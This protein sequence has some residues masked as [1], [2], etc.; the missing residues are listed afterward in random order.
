MGNQCSNSKR[1]KGLFRDAKYHKV[2]KMGK[3]RVKDGECCAIW[4]SAGRVRNIAGPKREWIWFSDVRFLDR[5]VANQNQYL[6]ISFR[7]GRKQHMRGPASFFLDP[8]LHKCIKVEQALSLNAFE[9]IVVYREGGAVG[10]DGEAADDGDESKDADDVGGGGLEKAAA[11]ATVQA[12]TS[13]NEVALPVARAIAC[14]P[15]DGKRV[16]RRVVRGPTLFIPAA[17]EW[18]HTFSWHGSNNKMDDERTMI[19]DALRLTKI[20]T[21]P[22]QLY[23][24]VKACR[25]SDDAQLCVKLMVFFQMLDLETM[26]DSTHDPIGDFVNAT[27]A[28]VIRF[29]SQMTFEDFVTR[30]AE[31][32]DLATFPVLRER[33]AA[34][35]YKI[36]KVVFRGYKA[37]DQLQSMHDQ[38]IKMRTK[39][40]LEAKTAEQQQS[41]EDLKLSRQLERGAKE[42]EM[43]TARR[44]HALELR[45]LEHAETM[46]QA[47][48]EERAHHTKQAASDKQKLGFLAQLGEKGVDL[49]QYLCAKERRNDK[50]ISIEQGGGMVP[51]LHLGT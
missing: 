21:L 20:R 2:V 5:F 34:I 40:Q 22:D 19:K 36:D 30:S 14:L 8:V 33:A 13:Q 51:H 23:Y 31:L 16:Q 3:R 17:N 47:E 26:L 7:D 28:D 12:A 46:R 6:V 38:A 15:A 35:G 1:A 24:N 29:T 44:S 27:S 39:L 37:S 25:T 11:A 49:T 43:E 10:R 42:R 18:V 9:A 32:N 45:K 48:E 50:V 41:I 4:D